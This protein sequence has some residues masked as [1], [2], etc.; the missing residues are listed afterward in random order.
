MTNLYESVV[1]DTSYEA[2][3]IARE[4]FGDN[5]EIVNEERIK[6]SICFGLG[7]QERVKITVKVNG[8]QP[9]KPLFGNKANYCLPTPDKNI[10]NNNNYLQETQQSY[11]PRPL[12]VPPVT[13]KGTY[14]RIKQGGLRSHVDGIHG[15]QEGDDEPQPQKLAGKSEASEVEDMLNYLKDMRKTRTNQKH[16]GSEIKSSRVTSLK[17]ED[18][19]NQ[20]D[21]LT[22][23]LTN[24]AQNSSIFLRENQLP[25][26]LSDLEKGLLN[27]ETPQEIIKDLFRE[28]R[29]NC[30]KETLCES[31]S[32]LCALHRLIK[33]RLSISSQYEIKKSSKPQV[34]VLM[35]PTGVGK[36]TTI[37][38]LAAKYCFNPNKPIKACFINIDFY[39]LG[40]KAQLQKYAEIFNIP[41]EDITS[42]A[43]LD[44]C[45]E[46]HKND[47]LII[48]DTA[49][50]SQYAF[51][52]LKELK[53]YLDRIPNATKYLTVS[54]TSKYSDLK[55]ILNSFGQVG[56][57]QII[58]TK[59][60]ETKTIGPAVGMLLKT[61]KSLA[62]ITHGQSVP[63][64]YRIASFDFF[65]ERIFKAI[66]NPNNY[67]QI[68]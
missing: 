67:Q 66:Q 63:E 37:A 43:S 26:G 24:L 64:D 62:Y 2:K 19:Q 1:A 46:Q 11:E 55:E 13:A 21:I 60:D 56:F 15:L 45:L 49:G 10:N 28:L 25:Q 31:K 40:A 38:K 52:D 6:N 51:Q 39:K 22:S 27:L 16:I 59:T 9:Q 20:L 23:T 65:E 32:S 44:Y 41:L 50:R 3:L 58:L 34:I 5:I 17:L 61:N 57:D 48:V 47:D 30:D 8:N 53:L 35:G 42:V 18:I 14:S 4:K 12:S 54:S 7:K 36:T 29:M 33:E 68:I